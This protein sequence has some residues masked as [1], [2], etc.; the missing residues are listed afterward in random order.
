MPVSHLSKVGS[1]CPFDSGLGFL[2]HRTCHFHHGVLSSAIQRDAAFTERSGWV[3]SYMDSHGLTPLN[4]FIIYVVSVQ[5]A[6]C[7]LVRK[8]VQESMS[9]FSQNVDPDG[10]RNTAS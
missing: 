3:Q 2:R 10:T 1:A 5:A 6:P 9:S 4:H 7:E 8:L